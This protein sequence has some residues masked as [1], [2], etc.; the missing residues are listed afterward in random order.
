[1]L[2]HPAQLLL[3]RA[4]FA[5]LLHRSTQRPQARGRP[6]EKPRGA[7]LADTRCLHALTAS[8]EPT[9]FMEDVVPERPAAWLGLLGLLTALCQPGIHMGPVLKHHRWGRTQ[10]RTAW[11]GSTAPLSPLLLP[12]PGRAALSITPQGYHGISLQ[13]PPCPCWGCSLPCSLSLCLQTGSRWEGSGREEYIDLVAAAGVL[14][15][16]TSPAEPSTALQ[17]DF[18]AW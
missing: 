17:G 11:R 12:A 4:S 3:G 5:P 18:P 10:S 13:T 2:L 9:I 6:W 1:M 14:R 16:C 8:K 15:G 7:V